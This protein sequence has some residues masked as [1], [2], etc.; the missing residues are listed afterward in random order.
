MQINEIMN[1][2]LYLIDSNATI[3]DACKR[4]YRKKIGSLIVVDKGVLI[5]I[6]TERDIISRVVILDKDPKVTKVEDIMSKEVITIDQNKTVEEA[7]KIMSQHNIK[8][9]PVTSE[10]GGLV[11]IITTSDVSRVL[12]EYQKLAMQ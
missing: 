9:L 10:T 4:L 7:S 1:K 6:I 12:S 2:E 3:M 8:K 11:G 5:G